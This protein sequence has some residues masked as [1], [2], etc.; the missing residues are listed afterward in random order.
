MLAVVKKP[1]I[2]LSLSG[3]GSTQIINWIRKKYD[4]TILSGEEDTINIE[5]TDFYRDMNNN[6]VGNLLEALRLKAGLTQKQLAEKTGIRQSLISDFEHGRRKISED[7]AGRLAEALD[8]KKERLLQN[9][10]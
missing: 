7:I 9:Q 8:F 2:E 5:N 4:V 1:S 6:R 10:D 3:E